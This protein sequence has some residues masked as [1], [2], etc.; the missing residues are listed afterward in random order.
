MTI[1][2][3]QKQ[4][5]AWLVISLLAGLIVWLL[6]PVLT[7]FLVAAVLAYVL[8]PLVE[9]LAAR[10]L[11]RVIAGHAGR[12]RGH[13]HRVGGVAADRADPVEATA[14]AA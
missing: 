13:H 10:R 5:A 8:H 3:A 14:V 7:P 9:R 2:T 6:A 12:G 1:T 11:P 4:T